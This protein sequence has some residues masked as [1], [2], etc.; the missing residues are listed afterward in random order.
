MGRG[1]GLSRPG[2]E[3]GSPRSFLLGQLGALFSACVSGVPCVLTSPA[4][5]QDLS[6]SQCWPIITLFTAFSRFWTQGGTSAVF[7]LLHTL[8][9]P[10]TSFPGSTLGPPVPVNLLGA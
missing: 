5:T 6:A 4:R 10:S 1:L 2:K 8:G 3:L 9:F 7:L